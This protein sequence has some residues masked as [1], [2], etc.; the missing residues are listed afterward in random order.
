MNSD[1]MVLLAILILARSEE[2]KIRN[3]GTPVISTARM[4]D[5]VQLDG[6][7]IAREIMAALKD[8]ETEIFDRA[9][10]HV[11][12]YYA[13]IIKE[14]RA[15]SD[16]DKLNH[17]LAIHFAGLRERIDRLENDLITRGQQPPNTP[18][19]RTPRNEK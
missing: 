17:A 7:R 19:R 14:I 13:E 18:A 5:S 8:E 15:N 16:V 12:M 4:P 2:E 9:A 10:N 11:Y 3:K 1:W 6:V